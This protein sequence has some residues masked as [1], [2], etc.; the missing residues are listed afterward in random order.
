VSHEQSAPISS[1]QA[2]AEIPTARDDK[3]KRALRRSHGQDFNMFRS[4]E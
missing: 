3:E 2:H 1:R 4:N